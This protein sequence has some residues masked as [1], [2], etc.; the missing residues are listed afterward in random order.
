MVTLEECRQKIRQIITEYAA[1]PYAHGE[2]ARNPVFDSESDRYLLMLVGRD[3][4]HY[5]HGC[6][7]HV[8]I[9]DNKLWIYRDGTEYGI[10]N[11]LVD[12]GI[13]KQQIVLGFRSP[14]VRKHT[15]FAMN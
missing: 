9:I 7:I 1:I 14:E 4:T 8:D 3:G 5:V 2:V 13:P 10:A 11:E 6:L 12:A 15:E